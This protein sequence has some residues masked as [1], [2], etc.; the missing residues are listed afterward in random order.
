MKATDTGQDW[1]PQIVMDFAVQRQQ[2]WTAWEHRPLQGQRKVWAC[3]W[4]LLPRKSSP[5][6]I[7]NALDSSQD[8]HH[9][10]FLFEVFYLLDPTSAV[11]HEE[12]FHGFQPVKVCFW[13][14]ILDL[15]A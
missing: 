1:S 6:Y 4:S 2:K 7:S 10:V 3:F 5:N 8:C 11:K 13:Q 14:L 15:T 9:S 12:I